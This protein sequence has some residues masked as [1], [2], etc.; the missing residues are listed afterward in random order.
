MNHTEALAFYISGISEGEGSF[1]IAVNKKTDLLLGWSLTPSFIVTMHSKE[2]AIPQ[3]MKQFF[4]FG[5]TY[6]KDPR[7][8]FGVTNLDDLVEKII[9]F[10]DS[11][12]LRGSKREDFEIW[13]SIVLQISKGEHLTE[14]GLIAILN[15]RK[16]L[17]DGGSATRRPIEEIIP[18]IRENARKTLR[19]NSD[20][21]IKYFQALVLRR[22]G[23]TE[24][25]ISTTIGVP[26][27]T[28]HYW[29]TGKTKPMIF[30]K[31]MG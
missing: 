18:S 27:A 11:H 24:A 5:W 28:I 3:L 15:Q 21:A 14:K 30:H 2:K 31:F 8:K 1:T 23:Y 16:Y 7:S 25:K 17:N 12:P 26:K 13:K 29:T 6:T 10:F 4:G 20:K 9:P 19:R 22:K